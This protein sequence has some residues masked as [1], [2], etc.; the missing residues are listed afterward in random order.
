M[1]KDSGWTTFQVSCKLPYDLEQPL[2]ETL[3]KARIA[4]GDTDV[5][6]WEAIHGECHATWDAEHEH[7]FRNT[8]DWRLATLVGAGWR[9]ERCGT[10]NN[11]QVHHRKFRSQGG[12]ND[13][14]NLESICAG[15]HQKEHVG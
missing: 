9:C 4:N 13:P 8:P 5:G 2:R 1:S 15:C 7:N 6:Q 10:P 11:L 12:G 14:G 3:Y